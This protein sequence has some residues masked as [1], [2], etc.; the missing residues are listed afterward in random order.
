VFVPELRLQPSRYSV[1]DFVPDAVLEPI[2]WEPSKTK[3]HPPSW[4]K[5]QPIDRLAALWDYSLA[6]AVRGIELVDYIRN[7]KPQRVIYPWV[8]SPTF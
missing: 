4:W 8:S 3:P 7:L 5:G 2:V 6:D 1:T